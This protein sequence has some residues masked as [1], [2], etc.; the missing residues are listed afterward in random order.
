MFNTRRGIRPMRDAQD[1]MTT[2]LMTIDT[3]TVSHHLARLIVR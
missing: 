1:R 2:R 3:S